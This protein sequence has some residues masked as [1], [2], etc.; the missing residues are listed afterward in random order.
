MKYAEMQNQIDLLEYKI[1][2]LEK[3]VNEREIQQIKQ[4]I[5][6]V[7]VEILKRQLGL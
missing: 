2:V 4:P 1:E 6:N 7:S 3:L 5:D